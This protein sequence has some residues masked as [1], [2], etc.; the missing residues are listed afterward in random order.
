MTFL[1]PPKYGRFLGGVVDF[2]FLFMYFFSRHMIWGD[3]Y[4][5]L[6]AQF[7]KFVL[8][9][10]SVIIVGGVLFFQKI[11]KKQQKR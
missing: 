7:H 10:S 6:I 3:L 1:T 4:I 2:D 5:V 8:R 9:Q 11:D